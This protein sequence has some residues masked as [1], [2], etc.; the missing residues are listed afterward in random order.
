MSHTVVM[1]SCRSML[2]IV[3]LARNQEEW[4]IVKAAALVPHV[5]IGRGVHSWRRECLVVLVASSAHVRSVSWLS[6]PLTLLHCRLRA[7]NFSGQATQ[8]M[9][10]SVCQAKTIR[11][12]QIELIVP[13]ALEVCIK[14]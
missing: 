11:A 13:L 5:I 2:L 6:G 12:G 14:M 7:V 8:A 4:A 9:A 10:C 3:C 1:E